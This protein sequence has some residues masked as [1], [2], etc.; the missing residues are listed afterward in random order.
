MDPITLGILGIAAFS[1]GKKI[2][3]YARKKKSSSSTTTDSCGWKHHSTKRFDMLADGDSR[4]GAHF[5]FNPLKSELHATFP[6]LPKGKRHVDVDSGLGAVVEWNTLNDLYGGLERKTILRYLE[7]SQNKKSE[8]KPW[9]KNLPYPTNFLTKSSD[10]HEKSWA[11]KP[12]ERY[13]PKTPM[14][15]AEI[16]DY[17]K[18]RPSMFDGPKSSSS[19]SFAH[20]ANQDHW[21]G[22]NRPYAG[23]SV[24]SE[25]PSPVLDKV[26]DYEEYMAPVRRGNAII[27][28]ILKRQAREEALRPCFNEN[29]Y[30]KSKMIKPK[31][32]EKLHSL[33]R[34][35]SFG[36]GIK[37]Y[38]PGE[39]LDVLG[40]PNTL[41]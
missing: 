16:I 13:L 11:E 41:R 10:T 32:L 31:P 24:Q 18:I 4:D 2:G 28:D 7:P 12:K 6:Q 30:I 27:D 25:W 5:T 37:E 33:S 22:R 26:G 29:D 1:L 17:G 20:Q 35:L 19:P 14:L 8:E 21:A 9:L 36:F 38:A 15:T 39:M 40:L 23:D 3:K 34:P